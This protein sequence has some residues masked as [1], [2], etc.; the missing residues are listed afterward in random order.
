M[1]EKMKLNGDDLPWVE[2]E[3]YLGNHIENQIN[4]MKKDTRVKRAD[5]IQ[6]NNDFIDPISEKPHDKTI[7]MT[8]FCELIMKAGKKPSKVYF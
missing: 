8:N 6:K 1:L 3:L 4:G 2:N 7:M 5:T